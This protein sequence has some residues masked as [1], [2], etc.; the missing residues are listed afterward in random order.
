M[1]DSTAVR[2]LALASLPEVLQ[3]RFA[4]VHLYRETD[5][6]TDRPELAREE[7]RHVLERDPRSAL[8]RDLQ[9][10]AREMLGELER[11]GFRVRQ[12]RGIRLG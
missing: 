12:G 7:L 6:E 9:R 2:A 10:Q 1:T 5:R 11:S 8:G 4:L 3:H